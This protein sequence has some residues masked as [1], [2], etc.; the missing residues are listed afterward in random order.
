M[1][2]KSILAITTALLVATPASAGLFGQTITATGF[3]LSPATA[4]IGPGPEFRG[5]GYFDTYLAFDFSDT[6][7]TLSIVAEPGVLGLGWSGFEPYTFAGF[8]TSILDM[9]VESNSGFTGSLLTNFS[10]AGNQIA[11]DFTEGSACCVSNASLVY[12]II[13][14]T[15][16]IPEPATAVLAFIGFA[17]LTG[18]RRLG[19][20]ALCPSK[21]IKAQDSAA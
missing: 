6:T 3:N 9:Y 19:R 15:S 18:L 14:S 7:L 16:P 17:G 12:K 21:A 8:N 2:T 1:H 20:T 11:I 13:T 5:I 4:T 10:F